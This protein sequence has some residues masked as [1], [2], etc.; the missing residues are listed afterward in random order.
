MVTSSWG[1]PIITTTEDPE[2]IRGGVELAI[3]PYTLPLPTKPMEI[4]VFNI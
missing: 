3:V 2:P 4:L 1:K